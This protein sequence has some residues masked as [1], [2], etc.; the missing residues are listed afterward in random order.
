MT[1]MCPT[2]VTGVMSPT[3][4]T[5]VISPTEAKVRRATLFGVN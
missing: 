4:T 2:V 3:G 5:E 1:A